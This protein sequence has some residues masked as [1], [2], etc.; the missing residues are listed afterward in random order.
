MEARNLKTLK[1]HCDIESDVGDRSTGGV[2]GDVESGVEDG[3]GVAEVEPVMNMV[4]LPVDQ[5]RGSQ[6]GQVP[7]QPVRLNQERHECLVA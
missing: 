3:R 7:V 6:R 4:E 5:I 2:C 1:L